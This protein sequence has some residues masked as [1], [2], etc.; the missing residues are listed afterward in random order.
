MFCQLCHREFPNRQGRFCGTCVEFPRGSRNYIP[1]N[2]I[3]ETCMQFKHITITA[4]TSSPHRWSI[5]SNSDDFLLGWIRWYAPWRRW[6]FLPCEGTVWSN[7]CLA[8]VQAAVEV[9]ARVEGKP[10]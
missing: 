5:R 9:I 4:E 6:C 10:K 7:D 8:C 3:D 2:E 1:V